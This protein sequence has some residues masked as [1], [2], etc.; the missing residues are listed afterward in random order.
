[1]TVSALCRTRIRGPY[2]VTPMMVDG[3][4]KLTDDEY[5]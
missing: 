1:M 5:E 2:E 4:K 3:S